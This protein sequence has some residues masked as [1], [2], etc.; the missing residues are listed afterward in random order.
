MGHKYKIGDIVYSTIWKEDVRIKEIKDNLFYV[1]DSIESYK[2]MLTH[3]LNLKS[4]EDMIDKMMQ[5]HQEVVD[6]ILE[7]QGIDPSEFETIDEEEDGVKTVWIARSSDGVL[8]LHQTKPV[9]VEMLN[10]VHLGWASDVYRSFLHRSTF[11]EITFEN[12]PQEIELR[13]K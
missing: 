2:W 8:T 7:I 10:S 6:E 3:E 1:V 4:R 9:K 13:F 11:P 12:S 5:K